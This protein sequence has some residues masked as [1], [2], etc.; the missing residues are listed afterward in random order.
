MSSTGVNIDEIDMFYQIEEC[1]KHNYQDT[2][3]Q[4]EENIKF[5]FVHHV[6]GITSPI[7][8]P[9]IDDNAEN[10]IICMSMLDKC[11]F[12]EK[13]YSGTFWR[14]LLDLITHDDFR[15]STLMSSARMFI[16]FISFMV[17]F[18]DTFPNILPPII[19]S[20]YEM[21]RAGRFSSERANSDS[22]LL[23]QVYNTNILT[24][25]EDNEEPDPAD[26]I[27]LDSLD[28]AFLDD[29]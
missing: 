4:D 19:H 21:H 23:H 12:S 14:E 25:Y 15:T 22:H 8:C 24:R 6:C 11:L 17:R 1:V 7:G 10:G 18:N 29:L 3:E 13:E 2:F 20:T 9:I 26:P 28:L 27:H 5:D 16:T